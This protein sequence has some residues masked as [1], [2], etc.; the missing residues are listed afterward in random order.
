MY[1]PWL[2]DRWRTSVNA[3]RAL[4][5]ALYHLMA[6]VSTSKKKNTF[7]EVFTTML[8][9]IRF[10]YE[11]KDSITFVLNEDRSFFDF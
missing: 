10:A 11:G 9:F 6:I 2:A 3:Q 4:T 1:L 5:Y 7:E 8:K